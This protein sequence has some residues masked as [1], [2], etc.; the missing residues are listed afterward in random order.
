M[1]AAGAANRNN[2]LTAEL[3]REE[4]T[5]FRIAAGLKNLA[6]DLQDFVVLA[7]KTAIPPELQ[8]VQILTSP[9][10]LSHFSA[11][12]GLGTLGEVAR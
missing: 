3:I 1:K 11:M 2:S 12:L 4:H 9:N 8:K 7:V 5:V 10:F 6:E